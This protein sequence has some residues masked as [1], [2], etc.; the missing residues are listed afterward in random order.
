MEQLYG[1]V[2]LAGSVYG[3]V[4]TKPHHE[5]P[6]VH[7]KSAKIDQLILIRR[8]SEQRSGDGAARAKPHHENPP[9]HNKSSKI[10]QLILIRRQS[11]HQSC[12]E[13]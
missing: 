7:N 10:D 2:I 1:D 11:E 4:E 9:M 3:A 8:E 13:P 6:P 5:N 12:M